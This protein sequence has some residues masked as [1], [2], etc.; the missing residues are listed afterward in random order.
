VD[1]KAFFNPDTDIYPFHVNVWNVNW[2]WCW[3][4]SWKETLI[5]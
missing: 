5:Q 4:T 1:I 3:K 2:G